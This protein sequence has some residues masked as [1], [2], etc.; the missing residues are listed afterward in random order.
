LATVETAKKKWKL[1]VKGE[2]WKRGVTGKGSEYCK[3]I[4]DFLGVSTCKAER[5]SAYT[6]GVEAVSAADFDKAVSGKEEK[7]ERRY[8]EK[9]AG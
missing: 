8:R 2:R 1:K 5:Q 7:W 4:A 6:A 9:M 3:G